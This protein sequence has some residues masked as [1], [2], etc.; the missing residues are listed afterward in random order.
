MDSIKICKLHPDYNRLL[1]E[2]SFPMEY[3]SKLKEYNAIPSAAEI[4][5]LVSAAAERSATNRTA[6]VYK[7][8]YGC[9]DLTS[10]DT[11]DND[12]HIREFAGKT[13]AFEREFPDIPNVASICVYP[14]F[15][16]TVGLAVGD[17]GMRITSVAGGFPSSQTFLEVKMLE[18][19]MAVESG[20]D[21]IDI[22]INV[23]HML[24][25]EYEELANEVEIL[26]REAGGDTVFKVIL[27]S[28][29]L[30]TPELIYKASVLSMLAGADFVKTSTGKIP[31]AATPDAAVAI[32]LAIR[33]YHAATG[34]RVGFKAA[35]GVRTPEDA[36]LY[37]TVVQDIL[38][39]EWLS[40]TLFR[41]G[42]SSAANNIIS[43]IEGRAVDYY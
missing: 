6:E 43:A 19:A 23:G 38:G 30:G 13:V 41:I 8:C 33:D 37:Y 1:S 34:R 25:G 10:L 4:E 16:E 12:R 27:E 22:V 3:T 9:I 24:E 31:V 20:A 15:V 18:V 2:I 26:R 35:G 40:P 36:A 21:E 42:A 32:C 14:N 28:G 7:T 39:E 11:A 5:R 29:A 17:S